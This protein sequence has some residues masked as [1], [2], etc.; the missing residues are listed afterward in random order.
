M[1]KGLKEDGVAPSFLSNSFLLY[2]IPPIVVVLQF[3]LLMELLGTGFPNVQPELKVRSGFAIVGLFGVNFFCLLGT[4]LGVRQVL[5]G[6]SKMVSA[7]GAAFNGFYFLVFI[8][9]FV[10]IFITNASN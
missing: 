3:L 5:T 4:G 9:F 6:K 7:L 2:C 10:C 8:L 1:G